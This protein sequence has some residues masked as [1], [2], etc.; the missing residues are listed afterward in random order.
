MMLALQLRVRMRKQVDGQ[1]HAH[2]VH[3]EYC[4]SLLAVIVGE[5]LV[6]SVHCRRLLCAV[7][8][9]AKTISKEHVLWSSVLR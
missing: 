8:R 2:S 7:D 1:T 3:R 4:K 5:D 9:T 6:P